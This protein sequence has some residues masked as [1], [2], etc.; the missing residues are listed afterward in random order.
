MQKKH[1]YSKYFVRFLHDFGVK[2]T[3]EYEQFTPEERR[4]CDRAYLKDL[5]NLIKK[6]WTKKEKIAQETLATE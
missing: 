5:P 3:W 1:S 2:G 6:Y 4:I